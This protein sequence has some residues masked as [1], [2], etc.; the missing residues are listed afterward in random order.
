MTNDTITPLELFGGGVRDIVAGMIY[1]T[2]TCSKGAVLTTNTQ[3]FTNVGPGS[4]KTLAETNM[5]RSQRLPAP[6]E[7]LIY[8]MFLIGDKASL[9]FI[10]KW[11]LEVWAG[12]KWYVRLPVASL[13]MVEPSY[14][15]KLFGR[16]PKVLTPASLYVDLESSEDFKM[17]RTNAPIPDSPFYCS[18]LKTNSGD[19]LPILDGRPFYVNLVGNVS[20]KLCQVPIRI[21]CC[22]DGLISRSV[23]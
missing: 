14:P 10:N 22:F 4:G 1:D 23:S 6:Q 15:K 16:K 5:S 9:R 13:I 7:A 19:G 2:I 17:A 21:T 20:S 8:K 3:F 12:D 18:R 11:I